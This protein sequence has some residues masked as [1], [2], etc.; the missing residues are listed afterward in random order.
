MIALA[1]PSGGGKTTLCK[2][3]LAKYQNTCL[4][5]SHTTREVRGG[6]QNGKDYFFVTRKE[7]QDLID[8]GNFI[9]WAEVHGNLYGTSKLFIDSQ[10]Q[11][12]KIIVL[13]VDVQGVASLKKIYHKDCVSI[14]IMP[15]SLEELK[16]RLLDRGTETKGKIEK[17]MQAAQKEISQASSFDYQI[18]NVHL[19]ESFLRL[20]EILEREFGATK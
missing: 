7:F 3:I 9:E 14:F 13:D 6:E 2:M 16:Q 19:E 10:I 1:S 8:Q 15:P 20:R 12:K 5:I 18:V 4:S 11:Q 17:R